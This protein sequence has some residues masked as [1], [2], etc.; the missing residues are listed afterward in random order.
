VVLLFLHD[1][2]GV[3]GGWAFSYGRGTPVQEDCVVRLALP[4]REAGPPN[5]HDDNVDSDQQV[6]NKELSLSRCRRIA[7]CGWRYSPKGGCRLPLSSDLERIQGHLPHKKPKYSLNTLF[8]LQED[9]VVRLALGS[10]SLRDVLA[11]GEQVSHPYSRTM[12]RLL[13]RSWGGG[14]VSYGRGTPVCR[15]GPPLAERS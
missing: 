9:C 6:V 11:N 1:Q 14:A 8:A 10:D 5:H 2:R 4:W 3:L 13:C 7:W 15:T 12:P